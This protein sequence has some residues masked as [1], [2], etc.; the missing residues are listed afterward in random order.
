MSYGLICLK[1][2]RE[3]ELK[4]QSN[5][6]KAVRCEQDA[7]SRGSVHSTNMSGGPIPTFVFAQRSGTYRITEP[8]EGL[9]AVTG[10]PRYFV[11]CDWNRS[12]S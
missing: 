10:M 12:F 5:F 4:F 3:I 7:E 2:L 6:K 8:S 1:E 9:C 11:Y